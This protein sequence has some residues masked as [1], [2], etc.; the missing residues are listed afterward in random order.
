VTSRDGT[1]IGAV[2]AGSGPPLLLVHGGMCTA[3]RWAPLWPVLTES[4]TVSAMDRRGRGSSED[5]TDYRL[6]AEYDDVRAV[7]DRLATEHG[8]PVAVF[9]HSYGA[10]CALGAAA[11]GAPVDR[12]ALYEPPGP[13]TVPVDW[14]ERV[15]AMVSAGQLGRAMFSFLMEVVGYS[16]EEVE[17]LRDTSAG[18]DPLPILGRTLVREAEAL[19]GVDLPALARSVVR[20]VLLLLG[21]TS[22]PWAS[23]VTTALADALP[24]SLPD[25]L[26]TGHADGLP[27]ARVTVLPGQGHEA[28]DTAPELVAE[29]LR[30]FFLTHT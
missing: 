28:V 9:G 17:A 23:T 2:T 1:R 30:A 11:Q 4:F 24:A 14:L 20:P 12:L 29:H 19:R 15:R 27:A 7:V 18:P 5:G 25:E 22:P 8:E 6:E 26:P 16:R 13:A 10:V 21:A 3:D